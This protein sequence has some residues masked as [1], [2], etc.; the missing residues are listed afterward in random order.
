MPQPA[1][2][3]PAQDPNAAPAAPQPPPG[4][5]EGYMQ[6]AAGLASLDVRL[7]ERGRLYRFTTP[8]GE[9]EISARAFPIVVLQRLAGLGVVLAAIFVVWLL[10]RENSRRGWAA[11]F[12]SRVFAVALLVAGVLSVIVGVFPVAGL[13]AIAAGIVLVVRRRQAARPAPAATAVA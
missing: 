2:A 13:V 6:I 10:G 3:P 11:I 12:N 1:T 9:L 8:R 5:A 4:D 7:P